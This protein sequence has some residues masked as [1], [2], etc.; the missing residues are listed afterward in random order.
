MLL[1]V[2]QQLTALLIA[3]AS[4][5]GNLLTELEKFAPSIRATIHHGAK[6]TEKED[7]SQIMADNDVVITSY[8]LI[9][10]D[11]ALFHSATW[12]RLII[13]EAQNIKNPSAAQTKII[14][15]IQ[16]NSRI[17]LTGTPIENRLMDLWSL[18]NF[19]N[20]GILGTRATFRK[21]YEIPVQR[22]NDLRK[23]SILKNLVE[24]FILRRLKTDKNII[25][26]LPDKIEQ[27]VYC[28]L[29]KEQASLYQYIVCLL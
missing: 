24:P 11:K 26:D 16:A 8:G 3:T 28:V 20:P 13:D 1:L 4:V 23:T 27:K 29:T 6:R 17:A 5:I 19:L 25:Q 2:T 15:A 22:D 10:Q 12:S 9:R 18:F 21:E 7:L 14:Y